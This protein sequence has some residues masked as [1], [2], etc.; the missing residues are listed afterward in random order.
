MVNHCQFFVNFSDYNIVLSGYPDFMFKNRKMFPGNINIL[1]FSLILWCVNPFIRCVYI[2]FNPLW[3]VFNHCCTNT[4]KK[5]HEP[6]RVIFLAIIKSEKYGLFTFFIFFA[7]NNTF[8]V[9]NWHHE[10][11]LPPTSSNFIVFC[12]TVWCQSFIF[13]PPNPCFKYSGLVSWV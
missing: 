9:T 1:T 12:H 5:F 6:S 3:W 11:C 2:L 10:M 7:H 4:S 8:L 13:L